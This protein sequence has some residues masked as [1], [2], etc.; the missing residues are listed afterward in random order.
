MI[1]AES[2]HILAQMT[3]AQFK[4]AK[5]VLA[6]HGIKLTK[7][8]VNGVYG[9]KVDNQGLKIVLKDYRYWI[10]PDGAIHRGFWDIGLPEPILEK[11]GA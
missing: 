1:T 9:M 10:D 8:R 4:S 7:K 6:R 2:N 11:I 5:Q 3:L